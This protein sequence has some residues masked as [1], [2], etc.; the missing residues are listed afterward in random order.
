M[1]LFHRHGL[2]EKVIVVFLFWAASEASMYLGLELHALRNIFWHYIFRVW[3]HK[4]QEIL[5]SHTD[6]SGVKAPNPHS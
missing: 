5:K 2:C 6:Y 3:R 4:Y 1:V